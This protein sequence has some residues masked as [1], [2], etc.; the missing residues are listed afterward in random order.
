[1]EA[2]A[3]QFFAAA[4][5]GNQRFKELGDVEKARYEEMY[6]T[7]KQKK[8]GDL[9]AFKKAGGVMKPRKIKGLKDPKKPKSPAGGA[10]GCFVANNRAELMK[11]R[12]GKSIVAVARL[13]SQR[14]KQL[15]EA[16]KLPLEEEFQAKRARYYELMKTYVPPAEVLEVSESSDESEE[17]EF[18]DILDI[19]DEENTD[20]KGNTASEGDVSMQIG[21]EDSSDE[22]D[23]RGINVEDKH[24]ASE[25]YRTPASVARAGC[26][27]VVHGLVAMSHF[28]GQRGKLIRY[29][30]DRDRWVCLLKDGDLVNLR[31]S[32][33][34]LV[35]AAAAQ[36]RKEKEKSAR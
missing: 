21:I 10:Y 7:A 33:F 24:G 27:V 11:E 3:G 32:Q 30:A 13:A 5:L 26:N 4:K 16:Q 25:V 22:H 12:P 2:C 36:V 9:A 8:E 19:E 34:E 1:M 6:D 18:P 20:N 15:S 17:V 23:K 14:W 35:V 29:L 28:N 31:D